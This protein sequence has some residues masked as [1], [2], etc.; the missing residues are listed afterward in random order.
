[1]PN[2]PS[3]QDSES[4]LWKAVHKL[5]RDLSGL[6]GIVSKPSF[7]TKVWGE[8]NWVIPCALVVSGSVVTGASY[9]AGLI[10]D[11]HVESTVGHR[12]TDVEGALAAIRIRQLSGNPTDPQDIKEATDVLIAAKS[13]N[14]QV[15]KDVVLAAGK[16]F[17]EAVKKNPDAWTAAIAVLD[18]RSFLNVIQ[19]PGETHLGSG[20]SHYN[21]ESSF[22]LNPSQA[23]LATI[24]AARA[25]DVP[26][27]RRISAPDLNKDS[28]AGPNFLRWSNATVV[29]DGMYLKKIA[30]RNSHIIYR[31]GPLVLEKIYFL[32]C[33]FE[34]VPQQSGQ[35][36]AYAVLST[37]PATSFTK[38]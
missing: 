34:V 20:Q 5:E 28:P 1:V 35:D 22:L 18:Y 4:A 24:G 16:Q 9:V 3:N 11:S 37:D 19:P 13:N 25:P 26:Q 27:L 17:V 21:F 15:S 23:T 7:L 32:N 30:F 12:L 38:L 2:R 36:L 29:L 14:L 6:R 31:G 33:T 10:I 8:R